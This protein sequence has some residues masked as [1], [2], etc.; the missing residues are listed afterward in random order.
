MKIF[1]LKDVHNKYE[2][3]PIHL[4]CTDKICFNDAAWK[5]EDLH[6]SQARY[7]TSPHSVDSLRLET[8]ARV[9]LDPR[10]KVAVFNETFTLP[11]TIHKSVS[12]PEITEK[13]VWASLYIYR[14]EL[15]CME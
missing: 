3:I 2:R 13:K 5:L 10:H 11:M 1:E 4:L 15:E 7:R 6:R 14:Q 8:A 12:S 9:V